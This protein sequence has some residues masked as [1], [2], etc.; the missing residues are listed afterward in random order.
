MADDRQQRG[1]RHCYDYVRLAGHRGSDSSAD[2]EERVGKQP[3]KLRTPESDIRDTNNVHP[4]PI[5][6]F[7]NFVCRGPTYDRHVMPFVGEETAEIRK[8][9]TRGRE[10][11]PEKLVDQQ[12]PH[13]S[14]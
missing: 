7:G 5:A 8:E 10:V 14:F 3:E 2:V 4:G 11:R 12:N 1:S 6:S 13:L 9:Y